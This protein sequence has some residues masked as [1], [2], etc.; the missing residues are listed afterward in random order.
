MKYMLKGKPYL[1]SISSKE[2]L[3]SA[4]FILLYLIM[5]SHGLLAQELPHGIEIGDR[6]Y[7]EFKY[8]KASKEY[9]KLMIR[10]TPNPVYIRK[11]VDCYQHLRNYPKFLEWSSKAVQLKNS[12]PNDHFYFAQALQESGFYDSARVEFK[13]STGTHLVDP[14]TLKNYIESCVWAKNQLNLRRRYTLENWKFIN[15]PYSE[16]S[17]IVFHDSLYFVS[18]RP[19]A[20]ISQKT[21]KKVP[22]SFEWTGTSF[23][24]AYTLALKK[25]KGFDPIFKDSLL[26]PTGFSPIKDK[27]YHFGPI[28]FSPSGNRIYFTRTVSLDSKDSLKKVGLQKQDSARYYSTLVGQKSGYFYD[29]KV[30][31]IN[32]LELW[33]CDKIAGVWQ[34]PQPFSFN[35]GVHYSVGHPAISRDGKFLYFASDMPGGYGGFDIYTSE[36]HSDGSFSKPKNLNTLNSQGD[37]EFPMISEEGFLYF[38]SN[39]RVGFGGL[40]IYKASGSGAEFGE[41]QNLGKPINSEKDDFGYFA[42]NAEADKGIIASNRE[43]GLGSDDLY[44]FTRLPAI[45]NLALLENPGGRKIAGASI[46]LISK[47]HPDI[48]SYSDKNGMSQVPISQDMNYMLTAKMNGLKDTSLLVPGNIHSLGN[49][50]L[51]VFMD[52]VQKMDKDHSGLSDSG[53]KIESNNRYTLY[54]DLNK[55]SIRIEGESL[56]NELISKLSK[57]KNYQILISSYSDN[58]GTDFLN[59]WLSKTRSLSVMDY[60]S[61]HGIPRSKI[62]LSWFGSTKPINSCTQG[63]N[64]TEEDYQMNRR[65]EI[66]I[67][68]L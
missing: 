20:E 50:T 21:R 62:K 19:H 25:N 37:D 57:K 61:S 4:G 39:G 34:D 7:S 10:K 23:L 41:V 11:L 44:F 31:F 45:L 55:K 54:Y 3:K 16:F 46:R 29:R 26:H 22:Q 9:E 17:P 49:D 38:S 28:V 43:G 67:L 2:V 51:L 36:I 53:V 15:T 59:Y 48:V 65:S 13:K 5:G 58:R 52:S 14:G 60:L 56:L 32:R 18:D 68:E 66:R 1:S 33:Y 40:D 47:D 30:S 42:I 64:C 63:V 35:G 8:D 12:G 24:K 6:Y 27:N